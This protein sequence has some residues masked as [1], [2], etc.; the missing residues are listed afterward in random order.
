MFWEAFEA[1]LILPGFVPGPWLEVN[2]RSS[3]LRSCGSF[4]TFVDRPVSA[5][6][7]GLGLA[8][9]LA[10]AH[11]ALRRAKPPIRVPEETF[12]WMLRAPWPHQAA[13]FERGVTVAPVPGRA[14]RIEAQPR[15]HG[16]QFLL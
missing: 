5:V 10:Q 9:I 16:W 3:V 7:V 11:A 15:P 12:N 6:F 8:P 2:L 14:E 4:A 13:K 1:A